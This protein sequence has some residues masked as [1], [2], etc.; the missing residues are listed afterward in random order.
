MIFKIKKTKSRNLL[1]VSDAER[2]KL[3]REAQAALRQHAIEARLWKS[4]M[5]VENLVVN[6][7]PVLH[8]MSHLT[9]F[10]LECKL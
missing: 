5:D 3:L 4:L 9:G 2:V 1:E 7:E 10:M 6:G 8:D